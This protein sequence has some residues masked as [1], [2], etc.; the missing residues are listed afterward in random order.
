MQNYILYLRLF[1]LFAF[2]LLTEI[3]KA[4]PK[5]A[6]TASPK[7][8]CNPLKVDFTNTSTN[9]TSWLWS[10]GNGNQSTLK[11]PSAVYN[12]PGKFSVTLIATDASGKSDTL[13]LK[14]YITVFKSPVADLAG[15][16]TEICSG[17]TVNFED[18]STPGDGKIS[19]WKWDFGEGGTSTSSKPNYVFTTVG[20]FDVTLIVTDINGCQSSIKKTKYITVNELPKADF[21][22]DEKNKCKAPLT[23]NFTSTTSGKAPLKFAWQ[24]GDGGTATD[25]NPTHNYNA[26]GNYNVTLL[27]SDAK[28]CKRSVVKNN[29]I[30]IQP[31]KADFSA[32]KRSICPGQKV[33]FQNL[34]T[35]MT[36]TG[37]SYWDFDNGTTSTDRE[38]DVVFTAPGQYNIYLKYS[39]DGCEDEITKKAFIVVNE[40]PVGKISPHDTQICRTPGAFFTLN[41]NGKNITSIDWYDDGNLAENVSTPSKHKISLGSN[42]SFFIKAIGVTAKGCR[43]LID[44][45]IIKVRGPFAMVDLTDK[46]GCI[47]RDVKAT[48][49]SQSDDPI[50]KYDWTGP[51]GEKSSKSY[52]DFNY[53]TFGVRGVTLAV[54]DTNGCKD[55]TTV[56]VMGGIKINVDFSYDTNRVCR[57]SEFTIWNHSSKRNPDTVV[58]EYN[59]FNHNKTTGDSLIKQDRLKTVFKMLGKPGN[60]D[61][62]KIT[63]NSYGCLSYLDPDKWPK[64]LILGPEVKGYTKTFC[65]E[66]SIMGL[67]QSS[68]YTKTYWQFKDSNN[69]VIKYNPMQLGRRLSNTR[70]LW[71]YAFN[72]TGGCKDSLEFP[73]KIDP[74][75][76]SFSYT[77][78][79]ITQKFITRNNYIGID[80]SMYIWDIINQ[81]TG[82]K[83]KL[84]QKNINKTLDTPGLYSIK[85]SVINPKFTCNPPYKISL[86]VFKKQTGTSTVTI[87]RTS[88]YPVKLKLNDDYFDKWKSA[89]W[90]IGSDVSFKDTQKIFDISHTDNQEDLNIYLRKTDS[91]NCQ[92][93][94]TFY[95]KI[96]GWK[97]YINTSQNDETCIRSVVNFYSIIYKPTAG[98]NYSYVWDFGRR[99]GYNDRDSL[100]VYG[101]QSFPVSL[102]VTD[103]HGCQSKDIFQ[104]DVQ[105]SS[106]KA[107]FI[108]S[109]TKATCP[110]L[111]VFFTDKSTPGKF[112]IVK[113]YWTFGDGTY[114]DKTNPGKLYI[115]S[116]RYSVSL[117]V[118]NSQ[119]CTDSIR[120]PDL[121]V[122]NGPTGNYTFDKKYGCTPL[123]VNL[124][125]TTKGVI[126]KFEFDMGDG[127]VLDTSGKLHIYKRPGAYIPRLILTDTTGCRFSPPPNDT[128]YVYPNPTAAFTNGKVCDNKLYKIANE[129]NLAGEIQQK[130]QWRIK[131]NI[132]STTD[133]FSVIF[134]KAGG[135]D[136]E[137]WIQ[138]THACADSITKP[139]YTYGLTP[140]ISK[141][142]TEICLGEKLI[143]N[144]IS[145]GDTTITKRQVFID[146]APIIYSNPIQFNAVKKGKIPL[147]FIISDAM[148]CEDTLYDA[149]FMK[150]GDTLPPNP[151]KM[152]RS[153]VVD[154]Y[155]TESRF[156]VS[157]EVDFKEYRLFSWQNGGWKL[158][159]QSG[160]LNDT[161][162]QISGLNTL[163][164]PYCHRI[165]QANFCDKTNDITAVIPHCTIET[166][167]QG[168]TN[169]A[170]VWWTPYSGWNKVEK[171]RIHRKK[172]TDNNFILIDSVPGNVFK[173]TDTSVY[174]HV[175]YDYKIEGLEYFGNHQNSFSD[176]ARAIP[177]HVLSVP[178]PQIWRTTVDTNLYTHTEWKMVNKTK[179]PIDY[180]TLY[181]WNK[182]SWSVLKDRITG[183]GLMAENDFKTDVNNSYYTYAVQATDVC[184][185]Q[186]IFSNPGRSILLKIKQ[187]PISLEP[188]LYW[189]QYLQWNE[190]VAEYA[191]E[192]KGK[193]GKFFELGRVKGSDTIFTDKTIPHFCEKDF[194]YR[195]TAYRNQPTNFPDSM[196]FVQSQSNYAAFLPEMKLYIPNVFTPDVNNLND[197]FFPN[198]I[199][200]YKYT[201]RI[202]NRYGQKLY[203]SDECRNA[204]DGIY[205]GKPAP[206]GVYAYYI[207][208]WDMAGK[209]YDFRGTVHIMR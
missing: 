160:N 179:F 123:L 72:D 115:Y 113:R 49:T 152:L 201:M 116:G 139:F 75:Q 81:T 35:P 208:A 173:Y 80:D 18:Q 8:G 125:T 45:A 36:G 162:M 176:T 92:Y 74:Q 150:V 164:N 122:V 185:T 50:T 158:S 148:G 38:P 161:N 30:T 128:I 63:A 209:K 149:A 135:K 89:K 33:H 19:S 196:H 151:L 48:S 64:V 70:D 71:I 61:T 112:P 82:I 207:E 197:R 34:S 53:N 153:T 9:A 43:A 55:D 198:G 94:D 73:T 62:L 132:K 25:E 120:I 101:W 96:G 16:P 7:Q 27:V 58:F 46:T 189:N 193:D 40:L 44:S 54:T 108:A 126:K 182:N 10:F 159:A 144:D 15:S 174:C 95:Y 32:D 23:V 202:Y 65:P 186:S 26:N 157:K 57:N 12:T 137:L 84:R 127:T 180:Y 105:N 187:D 77:F 13:V 2:F 21:V 171:Y 87:D 117:T 90:S 106:P 175:I 163:A 194:I 6:F 204:W 203:E 156:N 78:D 39:W 83:Y 109:N 169:K 24:F 85:L 129:S 66:D 11:S 20:A 190:G 165:I 91:N 147:Q 98:N 100:Q 107:N 86:R 200:I 199:Y 79:C 181:K 1:I 37:T 56:S 167:A 188:V 143:L 140:D 192:R 114:S 168:D 97:A 14:D 22:P 133:T 206:D 103:N 191:I 205:D 67:N 146:K 131:G 29:L 5:A 102:T 166:K 4:Q 134:N 154:D 183:N 124:N 52:L 110:P 17:E 130:V 76:V 60:I 170:Q 118:T 69:K 104:V 142:K 155:T 178:P 177:L 136:V 184:E 68:Y 138:T 121:V 59:W 195:V 47:P 51:K 28:G 41:G 172:S 42:G 141:P 99:K 93:V 31:P 145:T 111:D 119:G 88:C 3:G